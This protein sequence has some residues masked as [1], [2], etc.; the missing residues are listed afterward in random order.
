[1]DKLLDDDVRNNSAWNQRFFVI[2]NTTGF[3][4]DI[5]KSE[6]KSVMIYFTF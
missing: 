4:E 2:S 6:I 1:M 5:V 3:P